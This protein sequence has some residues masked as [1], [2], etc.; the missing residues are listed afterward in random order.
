MHLKQHWEDSES[1]QGLNQT[2]IVYKFKLLSQMLQQC[3]RKK[4]ACGGSLGEDTEHW[5]FHQFIYLPHFC[6]K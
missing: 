6:L 3:V 2:P 5:M 4:L 1:M